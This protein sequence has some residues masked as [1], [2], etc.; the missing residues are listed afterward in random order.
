MSKPYPQQQQQY[1]GQFDAPPSY[2][3]NPGP[4]GFSAPPPSSGPNQT[5]FVQPPGSSVHVMQPTTTT[6]AY[7]VPAGIVGTCPACRVGI[8]TSEFTCC[9]IFLGICLFPIGMI[10]CFMMM[11]RRCSNCRMSFG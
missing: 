8:L 9:G 3:P 11:E 5:V 6:T 4:V 1:Q 7:V 2:S 10:C